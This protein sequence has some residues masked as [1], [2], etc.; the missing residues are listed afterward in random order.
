MKRVPVTSPLPWEILVGGHLMRALISA[1]MLIVLSEGS[2]AMADTSFDVVDG[3]NHE[4]VTAKEGSVDFTG[5]AQLR[6]RG[7][8]VVVVPLP[9]DR[10]DT[11]D[12]EGRIADEM[13]ELRRAAGEG[14]GF[15]IVRPDELLRDTGDDGIRLLFSIEWF[16]SIFDEDLARV[17][18][19]RDLGV[20][21]ISLV[22][23]DPDGL[24]GTGDRSAQLT[25]FGDRI[26]STL[27]DVG[28]LI[29]ITHLSHPQKLEIIRRSA[30]PVL[31]THSL[32]S[33]VSPAAFNLPRE[34]VAAL[35]ETGGSVWVSFNSSDLLVG[36]SDGDALELVA[37]HIEVLIEHLGPDYVGIGTDLQAGGKYVPSSLNQDETFSEIGQRLLERGY[38][39]HLVDGVLGRNILRALA[40]AGPAEAAVPSIEWVT[41]PAGAFTMGTDSGDK[42]DQ[43]PSHIVDLDEY[44]ISRFEITVGQFRQFVA[45]TDYVTEVERNG[46]GYGYDG[47]TWVGNPDLSWKSPGF[48]QEDDHPVVL[49]TWSDARAFCRWMSDLAGTVIDLP[50][51]AQWEKAA[52]GDDRRPYPWG[53]GPVTGSKCNFADKSLGHPEFS[54]MDRD[55]GFGFTSPVGSFPDGASQHG[56]EDLCGNVWEWIRDLY[57]EDYYSRS[58]K[59]NPT[60]PEDGP[61]NMTRGG[62]WGIGGQ[63][64]GRLKSTFRNINT[65]G[66]GFDVIGFRV[67]RER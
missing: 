59:R 23:D 20:R 33:A 1:V 35:A 31:A 32:V 45:A 65:F 19:L 5:L 11:S 34:V 48:H 46:S 58:P 61:Y 22:E 25:T 49:V 37:D 53:A 40:A 41:V 13:Q 26:V 56:V 8:D 9:L 47:S 15:S 43:G 51:E 24:F 62:A 44:Q 6:S 55:D 36:N 54:T 29:D 64:E 10:S 50:T 60:G 57:G 30:A 14:A 66:R 21:V 42:P 2:S 52:R 18:R 16:E 27:N 12:L 38:S 63:F 4:A 7:I 3:H 39:Q 67:V 28:V 17:E